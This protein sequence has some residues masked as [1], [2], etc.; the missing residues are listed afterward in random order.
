MTQGLA[1]MGKLSCGRKMQ[2]EDFYNSSEQSR[3]SGAFLSARLA[4]LYLSE[5]CIIHRE[6]FATPHAASEATA[7]VVCPPAKALARAR[8]H[9]HL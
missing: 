5:Q 4:V 3:M 6:L 2:W 9:M 1:Q 7:S 8:A